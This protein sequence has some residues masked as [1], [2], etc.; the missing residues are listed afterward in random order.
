MTLYRIEIDPA[1]CA[2]L[3]SC[4]AQAPGVFR[5]ENGVAAAPLETS[6]ESVLDA[7]AACPMAAISVTQA[8]GAEAA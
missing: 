7:A 4:L 6:D 3:A 1:L 5:L 2:G 8:S